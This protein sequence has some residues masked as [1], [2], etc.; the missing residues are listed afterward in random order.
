MQI[1]RRMLERLLALDDAQLEA[2]IKRVA[3]QAG[4]DPAQL[5]LNPAN[6]QQIRRTMGSTDP[7]DLRRFRRFT[8]PTATNRGK[9]DD[10]RC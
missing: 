1:D 10:G 8:M 5:G 3:A 2:V 9:I 7:E 6:M 4:I